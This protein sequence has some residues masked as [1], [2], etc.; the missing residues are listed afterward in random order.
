MF[1]FDK[2]AGYW[3]VRS[4]FPSPSL[5]IAGSRPL[6]KGAGGLQNKFFW[7]FGSQ[8]GL[9]IRGVGTGPPRAPPLDPLLHV[10]AMFIPYRKAF[11]ADMKNCPV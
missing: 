8:F 4:S 3:S 1:D 9:K 2:K 7:L 10:K 11:R 6:D 5:I